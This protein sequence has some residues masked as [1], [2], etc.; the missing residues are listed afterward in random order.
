MDYQRARVDHSLL[1]QAK[2]DGQISCDLGDKQAVEQKERS[3]LFPL[4]ALFS[5]F[6]KSPHFLLDFGLL[7]LAHVICATS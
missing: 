7:F 4:V 3:V 2:R 1:P 6:F 5:S